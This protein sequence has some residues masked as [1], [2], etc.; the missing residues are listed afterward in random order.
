LGFSGVD[1]GHN[2]VPP[3]P[4]R[5]TGTIAIAVIL[6]NLV[7]GKIIV[8]ARRAAGKAN[9]ISRHIFTLYQAAVTE[10]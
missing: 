10:V 7:Y 6:L 8:A 3:P 9:A 1:S 5:I 2:L 4:D